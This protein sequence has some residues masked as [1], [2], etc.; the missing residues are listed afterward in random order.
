[1]APPLMVVLM[2][3]EQYL[4]STRAKESVIHSFD[5]NDG[6]LPEAGLTFDSLGNLYG[7]TYNGGNPNCNLGCG[8]VFRLMPT[9]GGWKEQAFLFNGSNGGG[10]LGGLTFDSA[11]NLYGTSTFGGHG[12]GEQGEVYEILRPTLEE[13][14]DP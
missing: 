7:T 13:S 8:V 9:S 11:H 14:S 6:E 1:M 3:W 12:I 2:A 4:K 10:L 5:G